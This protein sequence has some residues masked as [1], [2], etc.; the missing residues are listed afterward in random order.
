MT[1]EANAQLLGPVAPAAGHARVVVTYDG[2][3]GDLPDPVSADASHDD[4]RRMAQEALR[5]GGIRGLPAIADA[6]L[7]GFIV[8]P[9]APNDTY[10]FPRLLLRPKTAFGMGGSG[11][12]S[13]S[14]FRN[15][16]CP[17]HGDGA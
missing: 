8:D 15:P 10:P 7:S 4:V 5:G 3:T 6:D 11:G 17:L 13:C 9:A 14:K 12:C 1:Q 16:S 2:Q